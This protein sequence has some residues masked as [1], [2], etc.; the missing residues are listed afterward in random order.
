MTSALKT[1]LH[2]LDA[3]I[4][5]LPVGRALFINAS[6]ELVSS[7]VLPRD[8][9]VVQGFR[10]AFNALRKAGRNVT[11]VADVTDFVAALVLTGRHRGQNELWIA[12]ALERTAAG[13]LI[14]VAGSKD[15][16]IASLRK[17]ISELIGIEGSESKHHGIAFWFRRPAQADAIV[18]ALRARNG[19]TMVD[20]RFHTAPGMFSH[21]HVDVGSRLLAENLP[22]D[23]S[24]HLADF[25][26]GWGYLAVETAERCPKVKSIDLYEADHASV[27]AARRNMAENVPDMPGKVFWHD[28]VGEPV[29]QRY[30]AIVMN[31]PFHTGRAAEPGI[32]Q[33]LIAVAANA[34]RKGGRLVMVANRQLPYEQ[35]LSKHF[36]RVEKLADE[37]GFKVIRATR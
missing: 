24:G 12:E 2:P 27:E 5:P 8:M 13:G 29:T 14:L 16:G 15:D 25:C 7:D 19:E 20:G 34:L 35:T 10:P 33:A 4:L 9:L 37:Q 17:R 32:G 28:L 31:P 3:G 1:L 11:A 6:D 22:R 36:G 26:A 18:N 23:L 21:D 30:D